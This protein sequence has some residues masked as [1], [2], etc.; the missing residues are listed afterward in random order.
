MADRSLEKDVA[1][2]VS[3]SHT[4]PWTAGDCIL[5]QKKVLPGCP[6]TGSSNH[7]LPLL[8]VVAASHCCYSWMLLCAFWLSLTLFVPL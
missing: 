6:L 1:I 8:V 7:L 2:C 3:L 4:G 5:T